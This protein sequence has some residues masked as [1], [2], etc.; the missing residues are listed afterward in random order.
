MRIRRP[1]PR[2]SRERA[3]QIILNTESALTKEMVD[4]YTDSEIKE[5]M[6]LLKIKTN[7]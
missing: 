7:F 3:K 5:W 6:R 1:Q 4:K 2:V